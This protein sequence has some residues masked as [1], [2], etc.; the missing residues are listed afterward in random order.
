MLNGERVRLRA[1]EKKDID[2]I[3][4]WD[5]NPDLWVLDGTY[6]RPTLREQMENFFE[7]QA[8]KKG[9]NTDLL[10]VIEADE[11]AI[12]VCNLHSFHTVNR[13]CV[14]GIRI[15]D[16]DYWSR[17]YGR[18]VILLL[19]DYA[20][21]HRNV[22]KVCI[23]VN[24]KN[25]RAYRCY[26]ACGFVEEGRQREQAWVNGEYTDSVLMGLLRREW[27]ADGENQ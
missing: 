4:K 12:G 27:K 23:S 16:T 6:P 19:L 25:E 1:L 22:N 2:V 3:W 15:G 24:S 18:E 10:L 7:E 14:L 13:I 11:K 8:K 5:D 21:R 17:G 20:F 26:R 9:E